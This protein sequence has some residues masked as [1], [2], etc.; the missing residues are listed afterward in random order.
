MNPILYNCRMVEPLE[1][2]TPTKKPRNSVLINCLI[3][4]AYVIVFGSRLDRLSGSLFIHASILMILS[5]IA[6]RRGRKN[7][8]KTQALQYILMALGLLIIGF[9]TC[10]VLASSF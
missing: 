5:L 9:G 3:F 6:F 7:K 2:Q 8:Q 4:G 10:T 1:N